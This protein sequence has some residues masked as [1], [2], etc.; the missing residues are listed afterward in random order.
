MLHL[1]RLYSGIASLALAFLSAPHSVAV[2][3]PTEPTFA[4]QLTAGSVTVNI[5]GEDGATIVL[6]AFP[7]SPLPTDLSTCKANIERGTILDINPGDGKP[8]ALS[9]SLKGP[10]PNSF[11]LIQRLRANTLVC[12]EELPTKGS[13]SFSAYQAVVDSNDFGR[14]RTN[15]TAGAIIDNLQT[16]S[17]TSGSAS[18]NTSSAAEYLDFGIYYNWARAGG[19]PQPQHV[20]DCA[21]HK[22]SCKP[23]NVLVPG[24]DTFINVM[25]TTLPVSAPATT[26]TT[27]SGITSTGP[28][29]L[30]SLSLLSS[31]QSASFVLGAA[32]SWRLT[33][34]FKDSNFFLLGPVVK[35]GFQ[36]VLNSPPTTAATGQSSTTFQ[37]NSFSPTYNFNEAGMRLTW[38]EFSDNTD[39]APRPYALFDFAIGTFSN[40]PSYICKGK[41]YG[42][43]PTQPTFTSCTIPP[44]SGASSYQINASRTIL[45]RV[46][47][48]GFAKLPSY[49][50]L[51]GMDVN[52]GQYF[53]GLHHSQVDPLSKPGN[54]IRIYFGVSI[55]PMTAFKDLGLASR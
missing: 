19:G 54:D 17:S 5:S 11:A 29:P 48:M 7:A 31:Q 14:V 36:T 15:L 32:S 53:V 1:S 42:T 39:E 26:P 27:S 4:S 25:L 13:P 28:A 45:P 12:I 51:L 16:N 55:D 10:M 22:K 49:P 21:A 41:G 3:P 23:Y 30:S 37:T 47:L 50:F 35:G 43:F 44:T 24:L 52:Y 20:T 46:H 6:R 40:L 8:A 34:F 38:A 33:R 9:G 18:A 2:A